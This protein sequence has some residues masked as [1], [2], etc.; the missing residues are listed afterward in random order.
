MA[1]KD[2]SDPGLYIN[3]E[4]SWLEFNDRVLREGRRE[5][6]PLLERLKFLA[7][8]SS[9]LDEFFMIRVAGLK[10]Q[11]LAGVRKKE[12]AGLTPFGQL[13][14]I[15]PR[16]REML[17]AQAAGIRDVLAGLEGHG[18]C[19]LDRAAWTEA[20]QGFLRGHFRREVLGAL[21][22]MAIDPARP[23]PLLS[24][25]RLHVGVL[26]S[27]PAAPKAEPRLA[28]IPLPVCLTRFI[29]IPTAVGLRLAKLEDVVAANARELFPG[30]ELLASGTFRA[31][32]DSDVTVDE[33]ER[34]DLLENIEEAIRRRLRRS[35]VR[36]E[37]SSGIDP[38][39]RR[40]LMTVLEVKAADVY[41][42]EGPLD[43]KALMEIATR[44]GFDALANEPWPPQPPRD[45]VGSTDLLATLQTRDV[46]LMHP[47]E[48]YDPVVELI[49]RA[50][51]D[52]R[53]MAIKQTLYRTEGDSAIIAALE[54]AA[55]NGKQVT[56]LVELKARFDEQR[57]VGWAR[58]LEDAGCDVLYGII[59]LKTHAKAL[60][61]VR[62][63]S[64]GV[65]R[66]L[67]MSTGNY[68]AQTARLYADIGLMTTDRDLTADAA[69]LFNILTGYSEVVGWSK[70]A[71]AP[72]GL[73]AKILE[74]IDREIKTSSPKRPGEI[75]LKANSLQDPHVCKALYRASRAGVKVRLNVRGICCIRPGL[76]GISENIEVVSI[77]DRYLE[78]ARVYAFANA[79]HEEVY[80]SSADLMTRNLHKRLE[81]LF[82]ITQQ[83]LKA[84]LLD[85][86]RT[87]LADTVN[88]YR[89]GPDG[90]WAPPSSKAPRLR[91][92]EASYRQ[93]VEAVTTARQTQRQFRPIRKKRP[94]R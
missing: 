60:L 54:R 42:I 28:V 80:L 9:N 12:I 44:G 51:D 66:Y 92:Q 79:G 10:Q 20:D 30:H 7:I 27:R 34:A 89:L 61:V 77:V 49:E 6:T 43:G 39:L 35:V 90:T 33:D 59:G 21:T 67:H 91:A 24:G 38:R 94:L 52:P 70:L 17:G 48:S 71:I 83:D 11:H 18:L 31:T 41:E 87:C 56:V 57:N 74:L 85:H 72:L 13:R 4:L 45:L 62:R 82:P 68:N 3:R 50:A 84:R 55:A 88:G 65:R 47:Y 36:L 14:R 29:P 86:L 16:V 26:L 46:L 8:V 2:L 5:G 15:G 69:A 63:E 37:V 40:R 76:K 23:A 93:A 32:R 53:V 73:H 64:Q 25:L 19:L 75:I 1:K 81:T 78:H 58:R 22:P